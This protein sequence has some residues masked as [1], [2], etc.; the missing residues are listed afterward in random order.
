[1]RENHNTA[2]KSI[3]LSWPAFSMTYASHWQGDVWPALLH[4][5]SRC[6]HPIHIRFIPTYEWGLKPI[7]EYQYPC[8]FSCLCVRWSYLLCVIWERKKLNWVT[9]TMQCKCSLCVTYAKALSFC[10]GVSFFYG[11]CKGILSGCL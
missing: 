11:G 2:W 5:R 7:W 10:L 6:T 3:Y 4:G 9:W 8:V 1:M